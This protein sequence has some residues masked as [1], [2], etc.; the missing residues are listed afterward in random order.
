MQYSTILY[1]SIRGAFAIRSCGIATVR[2]AEKEIGV[3]GGE[4]KMGCGSQCGAKKTT[5]KKAATKK[6]AKKK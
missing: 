3:E 2:A 5:K 4:E 1:L 6:T